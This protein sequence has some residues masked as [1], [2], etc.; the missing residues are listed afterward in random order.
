MSL[1][2][3]MRQWSALNDKDVKCRTTFETGTN[4]MKDF[5]D[6]MPQAEIMLRHLHSMQHE[7]GRDCRLFPNTLHV[8]L[9]FSGC[10]RLKERR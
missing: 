5:K 10:I 9:V 3:I 4:I 7:T 1:F 2:L 8:V 6:T